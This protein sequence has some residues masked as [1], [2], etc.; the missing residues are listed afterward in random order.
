MLG[1]VLLVL[2]FALLIAMPVG[3]CIIDD[4]GNDR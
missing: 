3:G 1:I 2:Y 4:F